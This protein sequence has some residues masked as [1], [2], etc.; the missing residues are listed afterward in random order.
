MP[1]LYANRIWR[2]ARLLPSFSLK[3]VD[4][5]ATVPLAAPLIETIASHFR[6]ISSV[7]GSVS[8]TLLLDGVFGGKMA[9]MAKNGG[10]PGQPEVGARRVA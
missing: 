3:L 1:A 8:S 4:G 7:L 5:T 2:E 6:L 9:Q 10:L